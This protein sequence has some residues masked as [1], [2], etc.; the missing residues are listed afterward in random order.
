M[1]SRELRQSGCEQAGDHRVAARVEMRVHIKRF[2]R[3]FRGEY[4]IG[5]DGCQPQARRE[6]EHRPSRTA[7]VARESPVEPDLGMILVQQHDTAPMGGLQPGKEFAAQVSSSLTSSPDV[8]ESPTARMAGP[9]SMGLKG[10]LQRNP[11]PSIVTNQ[12]TARSCSAKAGLWRVA[13]LIVVHQGK[14][15]RHG[16]TMDA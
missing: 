11:S 14:I 5:V 13:E 16:T 12:P 15:V 9:A 6:T 3:R 10:P 7:F 8:Y 4:R 1:S 2:H